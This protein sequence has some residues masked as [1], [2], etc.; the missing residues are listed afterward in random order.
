MSLGGDKRTHFKRTATPYILTVLIV[1]ILNCHLNAAVPPG[2]SRSAAVLSQHFLSPLDFSF[3]LWVLSVASTLL[4]Q[5]LL[6]SRPHSRP[7]PPQPPADSQGSVWRWWEAKGGRTKG[8]PDQGGPRRGVGGAAAH[9]RRC[10][11][12][13]LRE[14]PSGHRRSCDRWG[15]LWWGG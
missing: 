12:L 15:F 10:R 9:R 7:V 1:C 11:Y 14:K 6:P 2:K 4:R 5:H 13:A 3:C 8:P